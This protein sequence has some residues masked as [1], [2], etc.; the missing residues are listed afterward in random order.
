MKISVLLPYK[1]NFSSEYAGAVSIFINAVNKKSTYEK[2]IIVYGNT[3]Y[4]KILSK[5]YYNLLLKNKS[6]IESSSNFYVNNFIKK[7]DVIISD[8]IEIHNRPNYIKKILQLRNS[9]KI[10]YFHNNPLEMKDSTTVRERLFLIKHLDKIIFNSIWTKNQ[11]LKGLP[12]IYKKINKLSIIY[13]STKKNKIDFKKKEKIIT[14]VGKLNVA[15]GYD[16]FGKACTKILKEFPA[17]KVEV[18][19][20][21]AR[22]KINFNHPR[23]N[24]NGFQN[25]NYVQNLYKKTSIAVICSRWDEPFGRTSLEAASNG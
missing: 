13:Q 5:N 20:D 16:L 19:G 9:K 15:K 23:F 24:I 6:I 11:F 1:E 21:E 22:E 7:K 14:F 2:E 10:L 18:V 8:I 3:Q 4:K 12:I 17:W 25:H